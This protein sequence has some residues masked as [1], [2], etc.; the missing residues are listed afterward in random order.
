MR[1]IARSMTVTLLGVLVSLAC[2]ADPVAVTDPAA[3]DADFKF[4]GEYAGVLKVDGDEQKWGAQVIALGDGKFHVVGYEGGLPGAGWNELDR[5]EADGQLRGATV[6]INA[7]DTTLTLQNGQILVTDQ[8]GANLGT[9]TKVVRKSPTLGAKPPQGAIVLFDGTTADH[10]EPGQRSDDGLLIEGATSKQKFG[11]F[12]CHLEFCLPYMPA[13]RGQ[14]RSNSGCYYQGRYEVQMLDSFGL[15][16]KD[17]EC[18]GI[19]SIAAPRI[20]MC[21]PPLAWQTYDVDFTTAV[22]D[23]DKKVKNARITIRHNG[24]VIH[25]DLELPGVTAGNLLPENAE[26]GPIH[27]QDHGNPVRYRNIWVVPK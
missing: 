22:F 16:G 2:A 24:V 1:T 9:L 19:Y 12:S 5:R 17:N 14:G 3:A 26:P 27:L 7:D 18:G 4:Q 10:F 15:E 11:N 13:A 21:L 23:Q 20:N 6:T 25:R 8:A